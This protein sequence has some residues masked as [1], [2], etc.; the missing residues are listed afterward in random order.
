MSN[1]KTIVLT[2]A[3]GLLGRY[4]TQLLAPDHKVHALVRKMPT[5]PVPGV[6][7]HEVDLGGN[8]TPAGLPQTGVDSVIHLAQ[9]A[10]FREVPEKAL[11]VFNVNVASTAKLLDYAWRAGAGQFVHASSGGVYGAGSDAFHENSP[12]TPTGNLGYYLGSK[13]C[14]EVLTQSYASQM[15]VAVLRFFFIYGAG[16]NRSMLIPRLV[17][18]VRDGKPVTLAG[19][20]GLRINPVHVSDAA[21]AVMAVLESKESATYNVAGDETITLRELCLKIEAVVGRKAQFVE[22]AGTAM[23]IIADISAMKRRLHKPVVR[24]DAG[25]KDLL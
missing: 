19:R 16:Q 7:Y 25:L 23:D 9:S 13:L 1:G 21:A 17:D 20:D 11:D 18:S 2:G 12:I 24:L 8:W 6:G 22:S 15:Q 5:D 14:G 10:H 4:L 3:S